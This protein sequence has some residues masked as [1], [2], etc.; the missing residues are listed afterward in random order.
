[1]VQKKKRREE[2]KQ[3]KAKG[4]EEKKFAAENRKK[5]NN[6]IK[7]LQTLKRNIKQELI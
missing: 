3:N 2:I 6:E 5:L 7:K 4:K 1:M